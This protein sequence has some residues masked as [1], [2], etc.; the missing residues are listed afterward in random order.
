MTFKTYTKIKILGD[1]EN[2]GIFDNDDDE[3]SVEEKI[4]GASFR[5][6]IKEGKVIFGSRTQQ[7][8]EDKEHK[9]QKNFNRCI[10]HIQECFDKLDEDVKRHSEGKIFFGECTSKHTINYDWEHIPPFLG[11]DIYDIGSG[12]FLRQ[13]NKTNLFAAWNLSVVPLIWVGKIKD[14]PEF[15]EECKK[16]E[17]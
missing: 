14:L 6:M 15:L 11:F 16:N 5:Y 4:D 3:I 12:K 9:F 7:L 10:I 13:K 8:T 2:K 1:V 17:K